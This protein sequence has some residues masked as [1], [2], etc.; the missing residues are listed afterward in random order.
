[1]IQEYTQ[2]GVSLKKVVRIIKSLIEDNSSR[3]VYLIEHKVI[4]KCPLT[5]D[6]KSL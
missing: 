3:T 6:I 5:R 2:S 4:Q 1:M